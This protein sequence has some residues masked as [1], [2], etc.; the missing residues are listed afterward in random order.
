MTDKKK[1]RTRYPRSNPELRSQPEAGAPHPELRS[2][3]ETGAPH[4][5][6]RS[7]PE[8]EAFDKTV[9]QANLTRNAHMENSLG[10]KQVVE[11]IAENKTLF[12]NVDSR[13]YGQQLEEMKKIFIKIKKLPEV[14]QAEIFLKI[15][16]QIPNSAS[17][18]IVGEVLKRIIHDVS[19]FTNDKESRKIEVLLEISKQIQHS[20][21]CS[22]QLEL[23][24]HYMMS[25]ILSRFPS[26]LLKEDREEE[27]K[28]PWFE[29][30]LEIVRQIPNLY[31]N[32]FPK[33]QQIETLRHILKKI[34]YSKIQLSENQLSKLGEE[35]TKQ[36]IILTSS[37]KIDAMREVI[38]YAEFVPN[39]AWFKVVLTIIEKHIWDLPTDKQLFMMQEIIRGLLSQ[40]TSYQLS[41]YKFEILLKIAE[42]IKNLAL[43]DQRRI[44]LILFIKDIV[45]STEYNGA[46]FKEQRHKLGIKIIGQIPF[47]AKND[48]IEAVIKIVRWIKSLSDTQRSNDVQ[49]SADIL[50]EL[51]KQIQHLN[52][53][54]QAKAV[55]E[56]VRA[57]KSLSNVQPSVNVIL[58]LIK[59]ILLLARNDQAK[60]VMEIICALEH[61]P[62]VQQS[63]DVLFKLVGQIPLLAQN[64]RVKAVIEIANATRYLLYNQRVEVL[65]EIIK[66][67]SN[68]ILDQR[69][70]VEALKHLNEMVLNLNAG[71]QSLLSERQLS[72]EKQDELIVEIIKQILKLS[73]LNSQRVE[74]GRIIGRYDPVSLNLQKMINDILTKFPSENFESFYIRTLTNP[75]S[76]KESE[77]YI[78]KIRD[79]MF[80]FAGKG[81]AEVKSELW[82]IE[83][84]LL[85]NLSQQTEEEIKYLE[86]LFRSCMDGTL[87]FSFNHNSSSR[88]IGTILMNCIYQV[89]ENTTKIRKFV[90]EEITAIKNEGINRTERAQSLLERI[91]SNRT[92]FWD[93]KIIPRD[94][95]TSLLMRIVDEVAPLLARG[96]RQ[97]FLS[98]ILN[99]VS[100]NTIICNEE[101][102]KIINEVIKKRDFS[103]DSNIIIIE[104]AAE[105]L[106]F[107]K[108]IEQNEIIKNMI[109]KVKS[110]D[111]VEQRIKIAKIILRRLTPPL[112]SFL[113]ENNVELVKNNAELRAKLKNFLNAKN[114]INLPRELF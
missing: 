72:K 78:E 52:Q 99:E 10:D 55:I 38:C 61:L 93:A 108:L 70:R 48:Q 86:A 3:P 112:P 106:K 91:V 17:K 107:V 73:D 75:F 65:L 98:N 57:T 96:E 80:L 23:E 50:L 6:L 79:D 77:P 29:L 18:T 62:Y 12:A 100:N 39:N 69:Q 81:V 59:C 13:P 15:I 58:E 27:D 40:S 21:A 66:Q 111:S 44:A 36:I 20:S 25:E 53:N 37:N 42:Q 76:S 46:S 51:I 45:M 95:R 84:E 71:G 88:K 32:P 67:I 11:I 28:N 82:R 24:Q 94:V 5:E 74:I 92:I 35:I 56:I 22:L 2:Q 64:D 110:V 26:S 97:A 113:T 68:L 101:K 7:Q 14:R 33:S 90:E 47:L 89:M 4:P 49:Q 102:A 105:S 19:V 54:D 34:I 16:G 63:A 9:M 83:T 8:A 109:K 60:A 85:Y 30:L 103:K 31:D 104:A 43:E 41:N 114:D 1:Q 87:E